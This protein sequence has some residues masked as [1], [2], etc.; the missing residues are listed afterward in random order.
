MIVIIHRDHKS[1]GSARCAKIQW[2]AAGFMACMCLSAHA[3]DAPS[4]ETAQQALEQAGRTLALVEKSAARPELS[5]QLKALDLTFHQAAAGAAAA[6]DWNSMLDSA[7]QLGRRILLSHPS[8]DF[9]DI[10]FVEREIIGGSYYDGVQAMD[11]CFGHNAATGGGLY[12]LKN[13]KSAAPVLVDVVQ[14]L[15]VPS[16]TNAGMLLSTGTFMSPDLSYDGK[17]I[18][19]AWSSGGR[20]KWKLENR[21]SLFRVNIDG[22]G[23]ARLS[24]G[25][26]DDFDPCWLPDGGVVFISTRRGGFGRCHP[27]PV[28]TYTLFGMNADGSDIRCLSYHETN[29]WQPSV[30]NSGMLVYTRWDYIDRDAMIAIHPWVCYPDGRNPREIHGNYPLPLT[31]MTGSDWPDGRRLRPQCEH[32]FRAIPNSPKYIGVATAHHNQSYGSLIVV[33]PCLDDDGRMSQVRRLT[34]E[35]MFPEI[36]GGELAYGTPWPFGETLYLCNYLDTI[37]LLGITGDQATRETIYQGKTLRPI[38]PIPVKSRPVPHLFP[39]PKRDASAGNS[40]AATGTIYIQNVTTTDEFGRLPKDA[41]VTRLRIVQVFPKTTELEDKP[42]VSRYSESLVRSSLGTVPV[43]KDGS[44]YCAVPAGK[45][46]YFQLLDDKGMAVQSMRSGTFLHPGEMLT[47]VGC[48]E[49]KQ[50]TQPSQQAVTALQRPPSQLEP[51]LAGMAGLEPV[52]TVNFYRL[53]KPVLDARCVS[54]HKEQN[55]GPDMSYASLGDYM[56]GFEG[57]WDMLN[58]EKAGGSRTLP[59]RFG[60]R[61]ARLYS[62][63]YL[64]GE[65]SPCPGKVK[66]NESELRRVTLWLDL[67]SNELGA[68]HDEAAQKTG[69][70]VVPTLQ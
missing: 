64:T 70:L 9:D 29:E 56:F 2:L 36:E 46:V 10:L 55:K 61:V 67:N 28:P 30:N 23:L 15:Q 8:L 13:F 40:Q 53:V 42:R 35:V 50:V 39:S 11:Q 20:E 33:D 37:C 41:N 54:C 16:G 48:H 3:A 62:E 22:S 32:G 49:N 7:R 58:K 52:E 43:E 66:L 19:F 47:C 45:E 69:K 60:A 14:G 38:D 1:V 17:T 4:R 51:E 34:P 31:T 21:F 44:V 26:F 57:R 65:A 12:L 6:A 27:R 59:G 5:K 25:N 63:G 18:L 24:D 68:Y